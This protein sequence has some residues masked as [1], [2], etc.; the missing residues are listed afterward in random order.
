METVALVDA[1]GHAIAVQVHAPV[2][3]EHLV[4][5]LVEDAPQ[6]VQDVVDAEVALDAVPVAS[7]LAQVDV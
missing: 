1:V 5:V 4:R 3:A 6:V 7:A 2:T